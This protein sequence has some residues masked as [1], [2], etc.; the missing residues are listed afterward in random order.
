MEELTRIYAEDV[1]RMQ[2]F[3][4]PSSSAIHQLKLIFEQSSD[5]FGRITI[6]DLQIDGITAEA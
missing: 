2:T 6:Y 5:F 1:N 3:D 4:L